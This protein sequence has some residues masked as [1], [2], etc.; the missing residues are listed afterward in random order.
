[1]KKTTNRPIQESTLIS[2]EFKLISLICYKT[3]NWAYFKWTA[4]GNV[5]LSHHIPDVPNTARSYEIL[6]ASIAQSN[7]CI[8][9]GVD[10][11]RI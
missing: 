8:S 7:K 1:V 11:R 3:F 6:R 2:T 10:D 9:N 5:F 4:Q